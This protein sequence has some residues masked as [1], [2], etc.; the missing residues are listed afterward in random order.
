MSS[1]NL[2]IFISGRG[3]NMDAILAACEQPE[4]PAQTVLVLSNC[5]DALGLVKARE[6]N[7]QTC[8]VDHRHFDT[9]EDFENALL[10]AISSRDIDLICLAGFMRLLSS[11]FITPWQGKIINIHPS[12]LP[13]YKGLNT[14][15]RVL[16]AG[17]SKTGCTVHY[18]IPAMDAGDIIAQKTVDIY[19]DDTPDV[20]AARVLEQE[21]IIYP[22]AI[23]YLAEQKEKR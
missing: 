7:I 17:E 3:S 16:E 4:F 5:P 18:V 21:H 10:E 19:P 12:L 14:H 20:L 23:R 11:H 8:V 2:A 9:K 15:A 6:A 1:I 13:D 22:Q